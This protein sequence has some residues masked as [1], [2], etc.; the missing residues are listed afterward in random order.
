M[1][2]SRTLKRNKLLDT[3]SVRL[4]ELDVKLFGGSSSH[5]VESA[6]EQQRAIRKP[7]PTILNRGLLARIFMVGIT[8]E[9]LQQREHGF[10]S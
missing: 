9:P 6:N 1:I 10:P 3:V 8:C 5:W 4:A 7:P 2:H